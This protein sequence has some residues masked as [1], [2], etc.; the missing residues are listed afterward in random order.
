M[1]ERVNCGHGEYWVRPKTKDAEGAVDDGDALCDCVYGVGAVGQVDD[2]TVELLAGDDLDLASRLKE[3]DGDIAVGQGVGETGNESTVCQDNC[4]EAR[5]DHRYWLWPVAV[6]KRSVGQ[7]S[8]ESVY[9]R[10]QD[11]KVFQPVLLLARDMKSLSS[12]MV[13]AHMSIATSCVE[14]CL[15]HEDLSPTV[16]HWLEC[17]QADPADLK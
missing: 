2:V 11:T 3:L 7:A 14:C 6:V 4:R 9:F 12:C 15:C 1:T 10:V 13:R 17:G 8:V 16:S 5:E